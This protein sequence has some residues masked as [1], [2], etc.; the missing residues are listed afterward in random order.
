MIYF[1]LKDSRYLK[2]GLIFLSL[3]T[4][5]ILFIYTHVKNI[6]RVEKVKLM[7]LE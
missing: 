2:G 3:E 1:N 7:Q 5:V 6:R 4:L